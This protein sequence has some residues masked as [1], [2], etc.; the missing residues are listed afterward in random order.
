[1]FPYSDNKKMYKVLRQLTQGFERESER[2]NKV[3][4]VGQGGFGA[5]EQCFDRKL[6]RIVAK[7]TLHHDGAIDSKR[8]SLLINEARLVCYIDHHG[9]VPIYDIFVSKEG[10]LSY[11]M[12]MLEGND[13]Q[14]YLEHKCPPKQ[15]L[16]LSQCLQ[17][18]TKICETMA[19]AHNKGVL[20]LDLKPSNIMIGEFGQVM[21]LDWGN[22]ILFDTSSYEGFLQV[23]G[24]PLEGNEIIDRISGS[25]GTLW[26]MPLEQMTQTRDTL[27]P[28]A[29]VFSAGVLLYFLLSGTHPYKG[30]DTRAYANNIL[31]KTAQPL[32]ELREDLPPQLTAICMRMLLP[33]AKQRYQTFE[34]V[35]QDLEELA[36]SGRSFRHQSFA[37]GEVL[38]RQ[39]DLGNF[40]L[41]IVEGDVEIRMEVDG[42]ERVVT[43]RSKGEIIGELAIFSHQPRLA[44]VVALTPTVT[45]VM[46][47]NDIET[48]L[49]KLPPWVSQMVQGLSNKFIDRHTRKAEAD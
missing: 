49:E 23:L 40:A 5:V 11:T 44:T 34:E 6:N 26:H 31:S 3:R 33:E 21:I 22:A 2:Y 7:K 45:R 28:A 43:T 25:L 38:L 19:F 8:V 20:H 14:E 30:D 12:K 27:T 39:G 1:M 32:Q 48:E 29:D 24:V 36:E 17:I 9:V 10:R 41:Q 16:P 13:L 18:F 15:L 47:R 42:Q 35:L 46:T 4:H 37:S